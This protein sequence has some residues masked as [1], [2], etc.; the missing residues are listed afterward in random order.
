[1][2]KV[3]GCVAFVL[4]FANTIETANGDEYV[5]G[6]P[7]KVWD[8]D[9][10]RIVREK[11][12]HMLDAAQYENRGEF[13]QKGRNKKFTNNKDEGFTFHVGSNTVR[14]GSDQDW[15]NRPTPSRVLRLAFHDC[16]SSQDEMGNKFGCDGCLHWDDAEMTARFD[17]NPETFNN[18][19]GKLSDGGFSGG[20]DQGVPPEGGT[21]NGLATIVKALEYVY[22]ETSWP[23]GAKI[24]TPS[25]KRRG[26]S[27]A[28]LWQFAANIALELEIEKANYACKYDKTNQQASVL[29]GEDECKIMLHRPIKFSFGRKDCESPS[30]DYKTKN[31]ETVFNPHGQATPILEDM[32]DDFGFS[33]EESIALMAAHSTQPNMPNVRENLKYG[34]VGNYLGNMYFKYLAMVPTYLTAKGLETVVPNHLILHGKKTEDDNGIP[35][36]EPVDGRRWKAHCFNRWNKIDGSDDYTGPCIFKPTYEGCRSRVF[37]GARGQCTNTDALNLD[38]YSDEDSEINCEIQ[39]EF[40]GKTKPVDSLYQCPVGFDGNEPKVTG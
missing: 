13:M 25:L 22:L 36:G 26:A 32:H 23:P 38:S 10:I 14:E 9:E 20:F 16:I 29:E 12:I 19:I 18:G 21:N 28:D 34:W 11:I 27:R 37:K 31:T 3:F 39:L 2:C 15:M 24:L 30:G 1:M 40:P 33:K 5:P 4:I 17:R 35:H 8:E 6:T 7:G